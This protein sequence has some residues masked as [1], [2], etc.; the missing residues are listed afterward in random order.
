MATEVE[1]SVWKGIPARRK[2]GWSSNTRERTVGLHL[3]VAPSCI[4]VWDSEDWMVWLNSIPT[5]A[6]EPPLLPLCCAAWASLLER[7]V[8]W[9]PGWFGV[10]TSHVDEET[11]ETKPR[12]AAAFCNVSLE[13]PLRRGPDRGSLNLLVPCLARLICHGVRTQM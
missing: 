1:L 2:S 7:R 10:N 11:E 9:R 6:R 8:A 5:A 3:S 4:L 12:P 13:Q